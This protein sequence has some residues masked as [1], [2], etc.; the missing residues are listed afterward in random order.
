MAAASGNLNLTSSSIR[1]EK[2]I[3]KEPDP[4]H[5]PLRYLSKA[6]G[7]SLWSQPSTTI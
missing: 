4:S 6:L 3:L 5:T 2:K 7:A 1:L